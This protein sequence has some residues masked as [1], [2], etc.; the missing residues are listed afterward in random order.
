MVNLNINVKMLEKQPEDALDSLVK[1][2][3]T[4]ETER[5][6]LKYPTL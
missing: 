4:V 1:T 3:E 6:V 5:R 2:V